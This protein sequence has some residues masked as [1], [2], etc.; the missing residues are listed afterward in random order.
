MH[1]KILLLIVDQ[2]IVLLP[3]CAG[4]IVA[5]IFVDWTKHAFITRF[6]E[7]TF[8]VGINLVSHTLRESDKCYFVLD[9][10]KYL[11]N[12]VKSLHIHKNSKLNTLFIFRNQFIQSIFTLIII[13]K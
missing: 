9:L 7:I 6:N 2:F 5:E 1:I 12:I 10:G 3:Y 11:Y 8:E 13:N 4:V